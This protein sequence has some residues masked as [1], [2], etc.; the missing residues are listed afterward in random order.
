MNPNDAVHRA[1]LICASESWW[2]P[3]I[4]YLI[5][6]CAKF[7][8]INF[9][10]EEHDSF[11]N[12]RK[13]FTELFDCFIC[14]KI[15]IKSSALEAAFVNAMQ[16]NNAEAAAILEMLRNY[17]DFVFFRQQMIDMATKI[18]DE[19]SERL[20]NLHK[21]L[22]DTGTEEATNVAAVLEEGED[23]VLE[24]ETAVAC[25]EMRI[26][27]KLTT[28]EVA[29]FV[30]GAISGLTPRRSAE[31]RRPPDLGKAPVTALR[32]PKSPVLRPSPSFKK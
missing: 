28:A 17:S 15:G 21:Q 3:I 29:H 19:T 24:R 4:G 11:L 20:I 7:S 26:R 14:K 27:L 1:A 23:A 16:T 22:Q 30:N 32:G 13:L 18:Q 12:F 10:N 6:N 2:K 25:E 8:G 5:T 9:T 31:S